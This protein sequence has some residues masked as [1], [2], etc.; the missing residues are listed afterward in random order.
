MQFA[1]MAATEAERQET[2]RAA[3]L[4]AQ[5]RAVLEDLV[6]TSEIAAVTDSNL[7]TVE[8][9]LRLAIRKLAERLQPMKESG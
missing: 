9:R 2:P 5:I 8:S 7:R 4:R 1:A 6:P 3:E